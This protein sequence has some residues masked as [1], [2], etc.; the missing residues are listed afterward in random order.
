MEVDYGL[1]TS[2]LLWDRR[3]TIRLRL[4]RRA[5]IIGH[6]GSERHRANSKTSAPEELAAGPGLAG[7]PDWVL[8][9]DFHGG[10]FAL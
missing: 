3:N 2:L 9:I 8:C 6:K 5:G 1:G 4:W 10:C 7:Q